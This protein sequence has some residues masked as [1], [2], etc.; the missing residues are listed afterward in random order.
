MKKIISMLA[1]AFAMSAVFAADNASRDVLER[2]VDAG[3]IAGVVS[4][5]S[6]GDYRE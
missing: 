5:V 6:D 2:Y 4:A 1:A 3:R